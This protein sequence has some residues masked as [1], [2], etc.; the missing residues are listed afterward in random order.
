MFSCTTILSNTNIRTR[1]SVQL[2]DEHLSQ[3]LENV[4][5][6]EQKDTDINTQKKE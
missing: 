4:H 1:N 2:E 3:R 6:K 5:K